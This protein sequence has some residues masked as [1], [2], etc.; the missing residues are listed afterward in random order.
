MDPSIVPP[1]LS[2]TLVESAPLV[3]LVSVSCLT[4]AVAMYHLWT[5]KKTH[6]CE[7]E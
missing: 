4:R 7:V 5:Y 3:L 6:A 1:M 2:Q